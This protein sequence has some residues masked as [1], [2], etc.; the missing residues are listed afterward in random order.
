[1][2]RDVLSAPRS[3]RVIIPAKLKRRMRRLLQPR[4]LRRVLQRI[5]ALE[6]NPRP[7]RVEKL[8]ADRGE[9][10]R[11]R[12]GDW[13]IIYTIDDH[14]RTVLIDDVTRRNESTYGR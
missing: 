7:R 10:Y 2:E 1:M 5:A 12:Q 9:R 6:Q 14:N 13:R 11:V 8:T 3:Y 4:E